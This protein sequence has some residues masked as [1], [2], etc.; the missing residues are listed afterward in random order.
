M[1]DKNILLVLIFNYRV[2]GFI[3]LL[4]VEV[5]KRGYFV[6]IGIY[7]EFRGFGFGKVLFVKL[8]MGLKNLGVFYMMLFIGENNFVRCMYEKEGF[9][10]VRIFIDMRK[11]DF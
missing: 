3:G 4:I 8:V 7:F 11:V 9:K 10:I 5:N 1:K 2:I 6:G